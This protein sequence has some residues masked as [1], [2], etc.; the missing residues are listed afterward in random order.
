MATVA[1]GSRA[2]G[3]VVFGCRWWLMRL[4]PFASSI[5]QACQ[6]NQVGRQR[7]GERRAKALLAPTLTCR[8]TAWPLCAGEEVSDSI[9][10][11]HWQ[12]TRAYPRQRRGRLRGRLSG[13]AAFMGNCSLRLG[14]DNAWD[15][16]HAATRSLSGRVTALFTGA[17]WRYRNP[18]NSPIPCRDRH[19]SAKNNPSAIK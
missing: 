1:P 13:L 17:H 5:I 4:A 12:R 6:S 9:R 3:P 18:V 19:T 2:R 7:V 14:G 8:S 16:G 15:H 11:R 10:L